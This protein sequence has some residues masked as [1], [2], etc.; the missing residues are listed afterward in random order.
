MGTS[1]PPIEILAS[2][3]IVIFFG[4]GLHEY[5]HCKFAD[6]AGDPTPRYYGRV[7]LN[8]FKHFEPMGTLMMLISSIYG[9]GIGWGRP[10]PINPSKMRNPR[11]DAFTA[12][13]AGP[14]SNLIQAIV[15]AIGL[16]IA[17]ASGNVTLDQV[18]AALGRD[19][20]SFLAALLSTGVLVNLSL[21][22]FNLIPF[23]P[24]DG[25]W[26]LGYLI[27]EPARTKWFQFNRTTG[28]AILIG[29]I[30][31]SQFTGI[32][33]LSRI[34]LPPLLRLFIFLTGIH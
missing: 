5:A 32:S 10:A 16:R 4:I 8:L 24:L 7:T 28:G 27:P 21:M 33:I 23:G 9:V 3:I 30:L 26:L 31:L 14:V 19:P 25:H 2:I 34:I 29:V 12:V 17:L 13:L 18:L 6:M 20:T 11:W 22:L 1:L 15:Y